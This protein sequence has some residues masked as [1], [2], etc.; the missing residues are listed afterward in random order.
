MTE[1]K[2]TVVLV[3]G[4]FAESA[5]WAGVI[6]LLRDQSLDVIA[7][8]NPLR[9]LP[10]DAGY[11]R[12]VLAT[13]AGPVVLVAHSYGGFVMTEA[14]AGTSVAGK[15][16]GLVYVCA[17]APD[18]GETAFALSARFPGSTL[19]EAATAY[20]V[21]TGGN[22]FAIRPDAFHRHFA[23]DV[24]AAEAAVMSATQRPVTEIALTTR[25]PTDTPAW[26]SIPSW[27]VFSDQDLI[28]PVALHRFM[29]DRAGAKAVSEIAGASHA[30]CVSRPDAVTV[31]IIEAVH[32]VAG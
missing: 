4:A 18:H 23:G 8:A 15:V 13:M 1:Q 29:A 30:L 32:A 5:S 2:P 16:A 22:E 11:V 26:K 27:F 14:A 10:G 6:P 7:V 31:S 17:F 24:P 19:G 28:I 21:T 9:S 25:L 20:P 12:D 3:H